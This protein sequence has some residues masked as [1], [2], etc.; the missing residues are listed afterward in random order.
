MKRTERN[1]GRDKREKRNPIEKFGELIETKVRKGIG[2][3]EELLNELDEP[4]PKKRGKEEEPLLYLKTFF[5]DEGVAT[6]SPSSRFLVRR[7][8]KGLALEEAETIVEYGPAD[9]VITKRMLQ[10]LPPTATLIAIERN[11]EFWTR[12]KTIADPRLRPVLGD[13]L[14]VEQIMRE[15]GV[16]RVDR[17]VSGIPFSFLKSHQREALMAA[18]ARALK[19]GGRFVAYQ[20]TTHLI[21]LLKKHFDDVDI[22]FEIRNLPPHFVFTCIKKK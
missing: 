11:E 3:L 19:P 22:Q 12:L 2:K 20:C 15:H 6:L 13:V 4:K 10:D 21:P 16:S 8:V 7:V 5:K 17:V 14:S 1:H 18:T 9:G